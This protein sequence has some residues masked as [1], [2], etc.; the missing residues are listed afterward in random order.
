MYVESTGQLTG[1]AQSCQGSKYQT[2]NQYQLFSSL[3]LEWKYFKS[4][5]LDF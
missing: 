3:E 2:E 1:Q 5:I 4:T